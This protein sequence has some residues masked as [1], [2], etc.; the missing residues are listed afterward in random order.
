MINL[1]LAFSVVVILAVILCLIVSTVVI[2]KYLLKIKDKITIVD[3]ENL[4]KNGA[5]LIMEENN[6][7]LLN[8]ATRT[9]IYDHEHHVKGMDKL[10][11]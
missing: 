8:M 10:R 6:N 5:Q 1:Q 3:D 7:E 9:G 4:Q 2:I 11:H